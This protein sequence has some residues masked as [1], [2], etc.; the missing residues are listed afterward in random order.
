MSLSQ[1]LDQGAV[2]DQ[3]RLETILLHGGKQA[4]NLAEGIG[5]F[6]GLTLNP[7]PTTKALNR[8]SLN[9]AVKA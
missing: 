2:G 5:V 1:G 9:R 7:K 8:K 4:T 3:V 6:C